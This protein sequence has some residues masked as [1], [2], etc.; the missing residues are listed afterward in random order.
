MKYI[1]F[2]FCIVAAIVSCGDESSEPQFP[3]ADTAT[4]AEYDDHH[5][6]DTVDV[7]SGTRFR[8]VKVE[9]TGD[10]TFEI[11]G[12]AQVFE[13]SFSWVIEDGHNEIKQGH[14]TTDAGAP[15]WGKFAFEVAA[16]KRPNTTLH[17]ILFEASA[18]DGS[19]QHELPIVLYRD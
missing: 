18:K 10:S 11:T 8:N 3:S 7:Y 15:S 6:R 14:G 9:K 12:E 1:L 17:L 13:A 5:I 4:T 16:A 19:R 2:V